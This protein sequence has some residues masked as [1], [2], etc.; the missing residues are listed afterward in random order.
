MST[1]IYDT[2]KEHL[3]DTGLKPGLSSICVKSSSDISHSYQN[4]KWFFSVTKPASDFLSLYIEAHERSYCLELKM[5]GE[6]QVLN[7]P[8]IKVKP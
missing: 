1:I 6:V 5:Q 2:Q 3:K 7:T 4:R 8:I